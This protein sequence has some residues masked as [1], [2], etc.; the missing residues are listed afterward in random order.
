MAFC[1]STPTTLESTPPDKLQQH[2]CGRRL[3]TNLATSISMKSSMDQ[4]PLGPTDIEGVME[5]VIPC[6]EDA[7]QVELH[8]IDLTGWI[9]LKAATG[10]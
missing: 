6:S 4:S 5:Q 8:A 7:L 10:Q 2:S 3:V 9:S 1:K